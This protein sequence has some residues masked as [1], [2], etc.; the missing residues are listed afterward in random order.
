MNKI[1]QIW[2]LFSLKLIH[3][4][5]SKYLNLLYLQY[6]MKQL[7]LIFVFM[8]QILHNY[9]F[10]CAFIQNCGQKIYLFRMNVQFCVNLVLYWYE[11]DAKFHA[12]HAKKFI[13]CKNA[14]LLRKRIY[15]FVETYFQVKK[16]FYFVLNFVIKRFTVD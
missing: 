10:Y 12:K 6:V 15:C 5:L 9:D 1:L 7:L 11:N 8:Q 16:I 3:I 2:K 4:I 13:L 14:K